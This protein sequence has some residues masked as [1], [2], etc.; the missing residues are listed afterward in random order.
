MKCQ[1][2]P[3]DSF[4]CHSLGINEFNNSGVNSLSYKMEIDRRFFQA[5]TQHKCLM[6]IFN[7]RQ[8]H[9]SAMN[10]AAAAVQ[11]AVYSGINQIKSYSAPFSTLLSRLIS[12]GDARTQFWQFKRKPSKNWLPYKSSIECIN[13][14][15]CKSIC[16]FNEISVKFH[17]I[18]FVSLRFDSKAA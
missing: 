4:A 13:S 16:I 9:S 6:V 2:N 8:Y 11:T 5:T 3:F 7:T 18:R 10:G 17:S 12:T 15:A 1:Y 14:R